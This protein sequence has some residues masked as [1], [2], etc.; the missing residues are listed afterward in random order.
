MTP[1]PTPIDSTAARTAPEA[2]DTVKFRGLDAQ[3]LKVRPTGTVD[4]VCYQSGKPQAFDRIEHGPAGWRWPSECPAPP[5]TLSELLDQA[6]ARG[7]KVPRPGM[8]CLFVVDM[9]PGAPTS[10]V[11]LGYRRARF[12]TATALD[13]ADLEVFELPEP[14][15]DPDDAD[16]ISGVIRGVRHSTEALPNR[17]AFVEDGLALPPRG[18][19][20]EILPRWRCDRPGCNGGPADPGHDL[21]PPGGKT[22]HLCDRCFAIADTMVATFLKS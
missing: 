20:S 18:H 2:G 3:V 9:E 1:T 15:I 22:M 5:P 11:K 4:L 12:L 13:I 17:F 21:T 6:E 8:P 16:P 14:P 19:R 10:H 7:E